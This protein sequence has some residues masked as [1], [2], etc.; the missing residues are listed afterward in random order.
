[1]SCGAGDHHVELLRGV[2]A[3]LPPPP[4]SAHALSAAEQEVPTWSP[5]ES[6]KG[7]P[8]AYPTKRGPP[9]CHVTHG[10][11]CDSLCADADEDNEE[12]EEDEPGDDAGDDDLATLCDPPAQIHI[13]TPGAHIAPLAPGGGE[14]GWVVIVTYRKHW[15]GP[16]QI[17]GSRWPEVFV[18]LPILLISILGTSGVLLEYKSAIMGLPK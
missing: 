18:S 3:L 11:S 8:V 1:M 13:L 7:A 12:D 4:P 17:M 16:R 2:P 9:Q 5:C 10:V 14:G 6:T 15:F